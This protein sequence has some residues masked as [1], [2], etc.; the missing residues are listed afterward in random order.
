MFHYRWSL[1]FNFRGIFRH[2]RAHSERKSFCICDYV[3]KTKFH[4]L[5]LFS[6]EQMQKK[7]LIIFTSQTIPNVPQFPQLISNKHRKQRSRNYFRKS[8]LKHDP[9]VIFYQSKVCGWDWGTTRAPFKSAIKQKRK[10]VPL[11]I[12][13]ESRVSHFTYESVFWIFMLVGFLALL[14]NNNIFI[15]LVRGR[16]KKSSRPVKNVKCKSIG[17]ISCGAERRGICCAILCEIFIHYCQF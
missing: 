4:C 10:Q 3:A 14:K 8:I 9:I 2:F 15:L 16:H 1:S 17:D 5:K 6:A 7:F 12:P 13:A 11:R